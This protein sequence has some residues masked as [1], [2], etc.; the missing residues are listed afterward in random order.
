VLGLTL[1]RTALLLLLLRQLFLR[2]PVE[3]L[4]QQPLLLL[5]LEQ[6]LLLLLEGEGAN[7]G[8]NLRKV[9]HEA[10]SA[11]KHGTC[12]VGYGCGCRRPTVGEVAGAIERDGLI[13]TQILLRLLLVAAAAAADASIV[14]HGGHALLRSYVSVT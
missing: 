9:E 11:R 12:G 5:Q 4:L 6:E 1:R 3:L 13:L 2:L 14:V 7:V 8:R 10:A